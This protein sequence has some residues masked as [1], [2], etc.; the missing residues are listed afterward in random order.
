M[1]S[2]MIKIAEL[3]EAIAAEPAPAAAPVR[4]PQ[5]LPQ[6]KVAETNPYGIE[7]EDGELELLE[8]NPLVSRLITKFA[9]A[10]VGKPTPLGE[11]VDDPRSGSREGASK[12]ARLHDAYDNFA[13]SITDLA[14][15]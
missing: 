6:E 11:P 14:S 13:N 8:N 3:L 4:I 2:T 5:A 7:L 10:P 12:E 15:R 9:G 1:S